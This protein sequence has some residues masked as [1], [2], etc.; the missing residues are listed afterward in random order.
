MLFSCDSRKWFII[1]MHRSVFR[2]FPPI[3]QGVNSGWP[4]LTPTHQRTCHCSSVRCLPPRAGLNPDR[5]PYCGKRRVTGGSHQIPRSS[6]PRT[7]RRCRWP[8]SLCCPVGVIDGR[9]G[10]SGEIQ[11][12]LGARARSLASHSNARA[13]PGMSLGTCVGACVQMNVWARCVP[14]EAGCRFHIPSLPV[15]S[16]PDKTPVCWRLQDQTA[17]SRQLSSRRS[18]DARWLS[19]SWVLSY[20]QD[21]SGGQLIRNGNGD[22]CHSCNHNY[23]S[24]C[25]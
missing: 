25:D 2:L 10:T 7:R 11:T 18:A 21:T 24:P 17:M 14:L 5:R 4:V 1:L 3:T 8:T 6:R 9:R 20:M 19:L 15:I 23:Q 22:I 12:W 16:R 13:S